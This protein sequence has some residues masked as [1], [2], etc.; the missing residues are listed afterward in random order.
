MKWEKCSQFDIAVS[1][2][3]KTMQLTQRKSN[4]EETNVLVLRNRI[5][6]IM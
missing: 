2:H 5:A 4:C 3:L 1:L 6:Y